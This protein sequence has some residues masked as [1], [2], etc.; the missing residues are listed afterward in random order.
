MC[1]QTRS[2][3]VSG[4]YLFVKKMVGVVALKR[5]RRGMSVDE[6]VPANHPLP[7]KLTWARG[8]VHWG[9]S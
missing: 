1:P 8:T 3:Q 2:S 6:S 7:N 4:S 9:R 5:R